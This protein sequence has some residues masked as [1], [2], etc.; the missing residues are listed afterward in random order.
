[1]VNIPETDVRLRNTYRLI[2]SRYPSTGILDAIAGP[3][4]LDAVIELESWTNDRIS[5]EFGILYRLPREEWVVGKPLA[6][7]IMAAYCH[8][9]PTGGRFNGSERGAWYASLTLEAAHAEIIYHR[10]R[11]LAEVGVFDAVLQER[12]YLA[13][14]RGRFH[15]IREPS[16]AHR[17]YHSPAGYTASQ[18]LARDLLE[19][20]SNG[21]VYCSPRYEGGECI[22]CFR[23]RL[24]ANVRPG[25]HYEYRWSGSREPAVRKLK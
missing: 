9:R 10:T 25:S 4:D 3:E 19:A 21:L 14:F 2:P 1:M 8:P 22:A 17:R 20:G 13:D 18:K 15:D 11:E 23:P 6:T 5:A 24:V 16:A 7:V 12:A